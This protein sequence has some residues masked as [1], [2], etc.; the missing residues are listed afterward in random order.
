M[1]DPAHYA[2]LKNLGEPKKKEVLAEETGIQAGRCQRIIRNLMDE[3]MVGHE[4]E[5]GVRKLHR[6]DLG[7]KMEELRSGLLSELI[8]DTREAVE[9]GDYGRAK[10]NLTRNLPVEGETRNTVAWLEAAEKLDSLA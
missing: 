5:D 4:V 1:L 10:D 3:G 6:K 9:E 8:G 2:V 7:G